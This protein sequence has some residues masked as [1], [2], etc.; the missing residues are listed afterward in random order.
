M[1][2]FIFI[3]LFILAVLSLASYFIVLT[4]FYK[5]LGKEKINLLNTF[6]YEIVSQFKT[7]FF[8]L[9]IL[10]FVSL[11]ST[12]AALILF[13]STHVSL[14]P[15][16]ACSLGAVFMIV[17]AIIPFINI[18]VLKEHLYADLGMIVLFFA[19]TGFLAYYSYFVAKAYDFRNSSLII[20]LVVSGLLFLFA[21]Y[22]IF[23]P[24]LF[25]LNLKKNEKDE[26]VRPKV[27]HLAFME[28]CLIIASTLINIPLI[29]IAS[30]L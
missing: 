13:M 5:K 30:V 19:S 25:D 12:L 27:F 8:Y 10:L 14:L 1:N 11:G 15:M 26:L 3:G 6:P 24:K 20:A 7:E 22:F 23:N 28:W 17:S 29:L 18:K 2:K 9:N 21:L 16:I 4:F